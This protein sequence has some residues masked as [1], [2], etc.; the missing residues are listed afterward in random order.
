MPV[1]PRRS[2]RGAVFTPTAPVASVPTDTVFSWTGSAKPADGRVY[3][4]GFSRIVKHSARGKAAVVDDAS[5]NSDSDKEEGSSKTH[6]P[7]VEVAVP[8]R[9]RAP[10]PKPDEESRFAIGDGVVV[11]VE[12]GND[13]I[14]MLTALWEEP[15]GDDD[16][17]SEDSSRSSVAPD[18][19]LMMAQIHWFFRKEDLPGVMRNVKLEDVSAP[20][21]EEGEAR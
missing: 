21:C 16:D 15:A 7:K 8:K 2:T 18:T 11:Q 20:W 10:A 6:T 13:G 4:S 19:P 9:R 5:D 1:T 3:Y 12:G 17:E 14:G